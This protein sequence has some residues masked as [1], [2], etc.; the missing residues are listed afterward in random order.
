[1]LFG[2]ELPKARGS[3]LVKS[4]TGRLMF[5]TISQVPAPFFSLSVSTLRSASRRKREETRFVPRG[6]LAAAVIRELLAA[7]LICSLTTKDQAGLFVP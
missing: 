1:M 6:K 2:F 5:R 3:R 4:L 7:P